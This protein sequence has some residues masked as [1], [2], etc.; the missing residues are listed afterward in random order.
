MEEITN[1]QKFIVSST[2]YTDEE[3]ETIL[4]AIS[5]YLKSKSNGKS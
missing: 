1:L 2:R 5:D 4:D 3:I